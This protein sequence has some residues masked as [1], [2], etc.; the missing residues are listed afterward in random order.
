M[1]KTVRKLRPS[2]YWRI[3]EHECWFTDMANKGYHLKKMGLYFA[4]FE[5]GETKKTKYRIDVST[6]RSL[7]PEQL[8]LY[9][10]SGWDYVTSYQYFHVF[11][12]PNER[13]APELHTDPAEQAYTLKKL[14]KK[15]G[16]NAWIGTI[17]I[18][19]MTCMLAAIWFLDKT[20]TLV[21]MEGFA[22]QQTLLTIIIGYTVLTSLQAAISIRALRKNLLSGNPID[23]DAPWKKHYR[24]NSIIGLLFSVAAVFSALIP[25]LQLVKEETK[26]LP[27]ES[28]H[29]PFVRL[30][31]VEDNI[32][33]MRGDSSYM[34]NKVDWSN[35]YSYKWSP[36]APLQYETNENGVVPGKRWE[37]GSGEYTPSMDT[38]IFQLRI[39]GLTD[40]LIDDLISRERFTYNR[41]D[42][43]QIKHS[44]FD[45][46]I[47]HEDPEFSLKEVF[48][49][50]GNIVM[51]VRYWGYAD[52]NT[53]IEN[54]DG[55]IALM[56]D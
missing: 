44:D 33:L 14:D 52:V 55:K 45:L 22:L 54:V 25:F 9:A 4:K 41:E 47:V 30:A 37:D 8:Q 15:L 46:L 53:L 48:A 40:N 24:F 21:L 26:T 27:L 7:S 39:T 11:S 6:K 19:F 42:Y 5:K 12:S 32:A 50:R 2:N 31:D 18:V 17:A 23:H 20:P 3:G 16:S 34:N 56:L 1:K 29:L 10:D 36:L 13:N 49:S 28:D 38:R 51:Y 43:V 35:R